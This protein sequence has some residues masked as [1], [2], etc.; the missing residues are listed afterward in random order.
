MLERVVEQPMRTVD[1]E[2][3]A[4]AFRVRM[5]SAHGKPELEADIL[6]RAPIDE[7]IPARN[8]GQV[9]LAINGSYWVGSAIGRFGF[10]RRSESGFVGMLVR[11]I[12]N[13]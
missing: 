5:H 3:V 8:R 13:R 1:T 4:N 7:L 2:L 11:S 6:W 9:D 10:F 12:R